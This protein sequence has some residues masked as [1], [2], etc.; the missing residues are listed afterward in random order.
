MGAVAAVAPIPFHTFL[1]K[2]ASRCNIDCDYCYVYNQAD[3]GWKRQ[4]KLMSSATI[5][6][7]TRRIREHLVANDKNDCSLVFHGGE[8]LMGGLKHLDMLLSFIRRNLVDH[9]IAVTL[10]IQSNGLLF[11]PEIGT[12][13]RQNQ[14]SIGVSLDG[15][16]EIND[17]HR[18]DHQG[19]PTSKRLEPRLRLLAEEFPDVFSGLLCVV[20]PCSNPIE[21]YR[22]LLSYQPKSIDFLLPLNDHSRPRPAHEFDRSEHPYGDWF[23]RIYDLWVK[24]DGTTSIRY[25]RSIMNMWLG[26]S[27]L[28]ESIGLLAVDLVVIE[29]NGDI[30]AVDSLKAVYR[31]A[32][33]LHFNIRENDFNEVAQHTGVLARQSGVADLCATCTECPIVGVCGG[34]YIPHRYSASNGFNNPSVYCRDLTFI[35]EHVGADMQTALRKLSAAA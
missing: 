8:P 2:I 13:C 6:L 34:G 18:V 22:H 33:E 29:T 19:R 16:A 10:G 21:V 12:F 4:P 17:R 35:I 25:F 23:A 14:I 30:E 32:A 5:D 3:D 1:L 7:A 20:D 31:G 15:P 9:G 27:S 11:T 24:H 28:V 26:R